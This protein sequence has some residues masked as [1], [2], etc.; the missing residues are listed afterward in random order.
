MFMFGSLALEQFVDRLPE[1]PQYCNHILQISHLRST[2]LEIVGFI[3]DALAR[4]SSAHA[5][6]D[7]ASLASGISSHNSAPATLGHVEVKLNASS[8]IQ[9][10]QQHMPLQLQQ[11][12]DI[13]LDH[14]YKASFG[15]GSST[16]VKPLLSSLGQSSVVT[17]P[18]ASNIN[19]LHS[20]VSASSMLASGFVR[21]SRGATSARFG[22]AL[23]I[24]TLVAAAEKRETPIEAPGSEVQDKISFI[25]NNISVANADTKAKE[26][27]EILKEQYYPWFAQYMVMKRASIEPN[28]H[29]LYLTFLEKVNSKALN[30]RD[31]QDNL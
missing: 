2:H 5:D 16:D 4:I 10:G 15:L 6:G 28:F 14:R 23:N 21:P 3:E 26:V 30:K 13:P 8:I 11:R 29:D 7:G 1:W 12:R 20:T 9:P 19:K 31:S 25:I 18:D 22:S 27:T 24:E 17:P